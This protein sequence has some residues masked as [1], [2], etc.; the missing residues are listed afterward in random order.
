M[1]TV[2]VTR[3]KSAA[4]GARVPGTMETFFGILRTQGIRGVNK[5]VNAVAMRQITGWASR[6]GIS[7]FAEGQIRIF[8][9]RE[10]TTPLS[11]GE[12]IA[13]S[14][15]GGALSCWN[16]PLEVIRV[17]MQAVKQAQS[18]PKATM[19]STAQLVWRESG[20]RGF[21]RGVVPRVGVASWATVCMVGMGDMVKERFGQ[22]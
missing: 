17:D 1:K 20:P 11:F 6:M 3:Q 10:A 18:G 8:R 21:F 5:G 7:R 9:G 16:Q 4:S 12:K 2:E 14:T 22:R 15:I 13:A 19:L